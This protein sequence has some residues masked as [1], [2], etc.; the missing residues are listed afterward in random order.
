MLARM[1]FPSVLLIDT[2][3]YQ[4]HR[5]V[6]PSITFSRH[7][8]GKWRCYFRKIHGVVG[9]DFKIRGTVLI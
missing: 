6:M 4:C 5:L 7:N 3:Q 9:H 8:L 2:F 1:L